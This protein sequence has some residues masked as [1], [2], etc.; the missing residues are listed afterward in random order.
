M[1]IRLEVNIWV[2]NNKYFITKGIG[3]YEVYKCWDDEAIA[4]ELFSSELFEECL[5]WIWNN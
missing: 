2:V 1:E 4:K 3:R 5:L